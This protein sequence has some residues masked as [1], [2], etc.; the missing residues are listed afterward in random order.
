MFHT[1]PGETHNG[2]N[3]VDSVDPSD[4]AK[5]CVK[6]LPTPPPTPAPPA[7]AATTTPGV[8]DSPP[9]PPPA[10][11][12]ATAV[13]TL[14]NVEATAPAGEDSGG[15][16]DAKLIG[17]IAG[18]AAALGFGLVVHSKQDI[19][20]VVGLGDCKAPKLLALGSLTLL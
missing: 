17:A 16:L 1:P 19:N 20:A 11:A 7:P 12:A 5:C 6:D 2:T 18:G 10:P 14:A 15:G 4:S 9:L 13:V 3:V 8:K